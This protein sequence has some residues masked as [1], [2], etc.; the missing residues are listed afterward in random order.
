[1]NKL[2]YCFFLSFSVIATSACTDDK[3]EREF[4]PAPD[5]SL[6]ILKEN[7]HSNGGDVLRTDTYVYDNNKLTTHTTLQEFYG[8]SLTHETTL[9][10]SGNEVTL[11]DENGNTAI[12]IL[13]SAGYATEC[14]YKLSDQVR[15]Y[16]FTYSG[17][18]HCQ[19]LA[20]QLSG[21][22]YGEPVSAP[23]P[24]SLRN[25]PPVFPQRRYLCRTV[26]PSVQT[27]DYRQHSGRKQRGVYKIHL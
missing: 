17:E 14:T 9:S 20:N 19:W 13:G 11:A 8:Q 23:L 21:G 18:Y 15:K 16:T 26:G 22:K 7:L 1:M 6:M 27:P 4:P 2:L 12:Y 5:F 3:E 24:A 25:L 10:Y